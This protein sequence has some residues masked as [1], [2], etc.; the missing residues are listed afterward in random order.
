MT[1]A[2]EIEKEKIEEPK[3]KGSKA[4]GSLDAL[5]Q[6]TYKGETFT[7]RRVRPSGVQALSTK[8][9]KLIV[10][11]PDTKVGIED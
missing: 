10:L 4:L 3:P 9:D 6:F 7:R 1:K 5:Q 2:K 11:P 8:G